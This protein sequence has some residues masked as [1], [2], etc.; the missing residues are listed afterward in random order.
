[1]V[2]YHFDFADGKYSDAKIFASEGYQ[3]KDTVLFIIPGSGAVRASQW[4][5]SICINNTLADG[6]CF[7]FMQSALRRDWGVVL[8]DPNAGVW[9]SARAKTRGDRQ[10][11]F[12]SEH[13]STV[14]KTMIVDELEAASAV[15]EVATISDTESAADVIK[16]SDTAESKE[17]TAEQ[18]VADD[19]G[20]A[21]EP[22]TDEDIADDTKDETTDVTSA[23]DSS[24][25]AVMTDAATDAVESGPSCAIKNV[26]IVAH[27]AGGFCTT[28]L[29]KQHGEFCV[30]R[31]LVKGVAFT[32]CGTP[33]ARYLP[34]AANQIFDKCGRNY[35]TSTKPLGTLLRKKSSS[36][37]MPEFSA[38][39]QRHEWTSAS[40]Y[41]EIFR[42][43]DEQL[44]MVPIY[45]EVEVKGA[46]EE[47]AAERKKPTSRT[48]A[49][50]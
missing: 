3:T 27:S 2:E 35:V 1:M 21:P 37:A 10:R 33:S 13:C 18:P 38:G 41:T 43:F 14:F 34:S 19:D 47:S 25:D 26:V 9:D 23:E 42:F 30:E 4:A 22:S 5:R 48:A 7:P 8:C 11:I 50:L 49:A 44:G 46:E 29:L 17:E 20:K 45:E 28:T 31:D 39:N 36:A 12:P 40:A 15:T 6:T 16:E 24:G 32:D